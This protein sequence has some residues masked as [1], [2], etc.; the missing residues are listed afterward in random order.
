VNQHAARRFVWSEVCR[1]NSG[2]G[3]FSVDFA[4]RRFYP[5][6]NAATNNDPKITMITTLPGLASRLQ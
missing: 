6:D 3:Y 2:I 5:T 1:K 4:K